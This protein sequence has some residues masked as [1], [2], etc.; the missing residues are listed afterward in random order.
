MFVNNFFKIL[1]MNHICGGAYYNDYGECLAFNGAS[2]R[3]CTSTYYHTDLC[4]MMG[5]VKKSATCTG[6]PGTSTG[7]YGVIFGNGTTPVTASDY[8]LSGS[9][10]TTFNETHKTTFTPDTS[11]FSI[12]TLY[13]IT[14]T[15][16]SNAITI[17][18]VGLISQGAYMDS[19]SSS[20]SGSYFLVE[21]T[22]LDTPITI[23]PNGVGQVTYTIR[24]NYPVL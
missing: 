15:S 7:P 21:R 11:G 9:V 20:S 3:V 5:C 1:A 14:N 8:K 12:S 22:L 17:S 10:I 16:S 18:E 4:T 13:T 23:A 19:S 6:N 2:R 24:I